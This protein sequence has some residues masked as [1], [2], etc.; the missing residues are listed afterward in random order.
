MKR[1]NEDDWRKLRRLLEYLFGT[2]NE[3]LRLGSDGLSVMGTYIDG[4]HG[5]H[6][7]YRGHNGGC[8][9]LGRGCVM[10]KSQKQK[11]NTKSSTE[12]EIVA[13][14][15]LLPEPIWGN[16]FMGAQG[17]EL[18]L[19]TYQDNMSAMKMEKNGKRSCSKR[20]K[21]I[22]IRFFF[23]KDY[24][25]RGE[26]ILEYCPTELMIADFFTKPL[27]GSLFR[28]MRD[29]VLGRVTVEEFMSQC[30]P[31]KERVGENVISEKPKRAKLVNDD[32]HRNDKIMKKN[33]GRKR[34]IRKSSKLTIG[35]NPTL[36]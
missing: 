16:K 19:K 26:V 28:K 11:M 21:H 15:D 6:E 5:V 32:V 12:T 3:H 36:R 30:P 29:V 31:S 7:D 4:A 18:K 27:Q 2:I 20:T 9:T 13:Y 35:D 14:S 25:E 1:P 8:V 24:I 34:T 17:Y 23:C 33:R 10:S 22:D